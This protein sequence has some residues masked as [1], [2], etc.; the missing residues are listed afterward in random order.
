VYR[1]CDWEIYQI[2]WI[3]RFIVKDPAK[4]FF[5]TPE[6][7][8]DPVPTDKKKEMRKRASKEVLAAELGPSVAADKKVKT[9]APV[10]AAATP[11]QGACC[12][13]H[14]TNSHDL[15]TCHTVYSLTESRKK[16]FTEHGTAG[17][18]SNC[19]SCG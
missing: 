11:T 5:I 9:E 8:N 1:S 4:Q 14:E 6:A 17:N 16:C 18:I 3:R 19:Y 10:V 7:A 12:P 13:I 2:H 15:N